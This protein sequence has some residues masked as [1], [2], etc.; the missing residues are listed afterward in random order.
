M[1]EEEVFKVSSLLSHIRKQNIEVKALF[2]FE[3]RVVFLVCSYKDVG[4]ELFVYIPSKY[5]IT[6][7]KSIGLPL[8][9]L[10]FDEEDSTRNNESIFINQTV[11]TAV[12]KEKKEKIMSLHRF[13]PLLAEQSYKLLYL[14]DYYMV[15]IDR[16][17]EISN[18]I[19][20]SPPIMKGYYFLTDMEYFLKAGNGIK[21][22]NEIKQ[23]ENTEWIGQEINYNN[24]Y[25]IPLSTI[26]SFNFERIDLIKIDVEGMEEDVF[27]GFLNTIERLK[28][29]IFFEHSKSNKN[30]LEMILKSRGY[31][32]Q[33]EGNNALAIH[34]ESQITINLSNFNL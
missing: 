14:D 33:Y 26:D 20:S 13:I 31:D 24:T 8:Y 34:N 22:W 2:S 12:R 9:E 1:S 18:F 27:D 3:N 19:L 16:H 29:T 11:S 25:E 32:I 15:F 21:V 5:N 4:L 17:N 28:P 7:E 30:C 10:G 6:A 23:R